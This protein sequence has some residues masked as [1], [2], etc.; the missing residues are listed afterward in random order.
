[1]RAKDALIALTAVVG[2]MWLVQAF[3][4][5]GTIEDTIMSGGVMGSLVL[6]TLTAK[7]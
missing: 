2:A 1:M 3:S 7:K 5:K 4:T 6:Y